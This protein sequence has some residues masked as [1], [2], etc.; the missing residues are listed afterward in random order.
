MGLQDDLQK[1]DQTNAF[2]VGL[3][4]ISC[5][6]DGVH[7]TQSVH[8]GIYRNGGLQSPG[9]KARVVDRDGRGQIF[10]GFHYQVQNE[11]ESAWYNR[12][13]K[14]H[15]FKVNDLVL[16]YDSKFDKF[17]VKFRLHWL[18]PYEIKEITNGGVVEL[19]KLNGQLFP[20]KVNGS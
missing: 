6:A 14:L 1:D 2:E 7:C 19:V 9:R 11:L 18:G 12:H 15:T 17:P 8:S 4:F 10:V 13:I 5:D 20:G 16:L 3:W